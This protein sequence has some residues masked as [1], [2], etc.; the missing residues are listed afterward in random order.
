VR[1]LRPEPHHCTS[2]SAVITT[3]KRQPLQ[4]GGQGGSGPGHRGPV[5]LSP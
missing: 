3:N 2:Q 4:A 5:Q 1:G